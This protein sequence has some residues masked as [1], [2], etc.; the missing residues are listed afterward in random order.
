MIVRDILAELYSK[1]ATGD[2][3]LV[4][5]F[6]LEVFEGYSFH[7]RLVPVDELLRQIDVDKLST[8]ALVSILTATLSFGKR[9]ANRLVY[10]NLFAMRTLR[11]FNSDPNTVY[12]INALLGGLI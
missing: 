2:K 10:H 8:S 12:R 11:K 4:A 5:D 3:E 9:G 7:G 6:V 1:S